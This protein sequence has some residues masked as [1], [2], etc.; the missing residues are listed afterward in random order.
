MELKLNK[1]QVITTQDELA[2]LEAESGEHF[3]YG[4][5]LF[6]NRSLVGSLVATELVIRTYKT[7][8]K[9]DVSLSAFEGLKPSNQALTVLNLD[10]RGLVRSIQARA[11][12][13]MAAIASGRKDELAVR[14]FSV[15]G[16]VEKASSGVGYTSLQSSAQQNGTAVYG[17]LNRTPT[18]NMQED[19]TSTL[20]S[21]ELLKVYNTDPASVLTARYSTA[22]PGEV[23]GG[24]RAPT[25]T[26]SN[27]PGPAVQLVEKLV[28]MNGP[29]QSQQD[30]TVSSVTAYSLKTAEVVPVTF[31]VSIPKGA[32]GEADFYVM[33]TVYDN[34]SNI[35]QE[36]V[37]QVQHTRLLQEHRVVKTAPTLGVVIL[38]EQGKHLVQLQ[39]QDP[40]GVGVRLYKTVFNETVKQTPRQL[41]VG[42]YLLAPGETKTVLLSSGDIGKVLYRALS[43]GKNQQQGASFNSVVL[44]CY[45]STTLTSTTE[46]NPFAY[47]DAKYT[48]GGLNIVVGDVP[49]DTAFI[50]LYKLKEG[51]DEAGVQL[52]TFFVGGMG[53]TA[54]Y[55][56]L[57]SDLQTYGQYSYWC[58]LTDIKG[59]QRV[60]SGLVELV[61]RP[62][63]LDYATVTVTEPTITNTQSPNTSKQLFDVGFQVQY[64]I[65]ETLEDSVRALLASQGLTEFYGSDI[66][67]ER[68]RQLLVTKVELRD[69]DSNDKLFMAFTGDDYTQSNTKFG[70]IDKPGSYTFE[71]TTYVRNPATLLESVVRTGSSTTRQNGSLSPPTYTYQPYIT[72]N[73]YGLQNGVLP[74]SDGDEFVTQLGLNQLELGSVTSID[75]VDVQLTPPQPTIINPRTALVNSK[76]VKLTWSVNG[77]QDGISHF[78]VR[79]RNHTTNTV[80]ILGAAH[81]INQQNSYVFYDQIRPTETGVFSYV[82]TLVGFDWLDKS[83][84]TT[85]E[86]TV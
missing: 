27:L 55:N 80:D 37:R 1:S 75:Y 63:Q 31:S 12:R 72:N 5:K 81:G 43:Y 71:L 68:L 84:T 22:T 66:T 6:V 79:R 49:N 35:V 48:V 61:Y 4:F 42:D 57:D 11:S 25:S 69:N 21:D 3:H 60:G 36:L 33:L 30:S 76:T 45:P 85:P 41:L 54:R 58:E 7:D 26:T 82:L 9:G 83:E 8:P 51:V 28:S 19:R 44:C 47:I 29:Q 78:V 74:K 62:K 65:T 13:T 32:V 67:R 14:R 59:M 18:G 39:Q 56:Y 73:P 10:T 52:A 15:P 17:S 2:T 53:N 46:Q 23:Y 70:L 50:S 20:L 34:D 77:N 64:S 16:L 86:V 24:A 40:N 38:G